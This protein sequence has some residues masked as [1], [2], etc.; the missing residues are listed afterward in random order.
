MIDFITTTRAYEAG[1]YDSAGSLR[2]R[3]GCTAAM[4]CPAKTPST[5]TRELLQV[6]FGMYVNREFPPFWRVAVV[7]RVRYCPIL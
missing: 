4:L 2:D 1:V 7:W 6:A 5:Q 3:T